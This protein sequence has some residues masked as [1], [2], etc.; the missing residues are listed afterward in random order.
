MLLLAAL[1]AGLVIE[2]VLR[3]HGEARLRR[4][5]S[6]LREAGRRD[7]EKLEVLEAELLQ[8]RREKAG[9]PT[10]TAGESRLVKGL[11]AKLRAK[12]APGAEPADLP[13]PAPPEGTAEETVSSP[14][15]SAAE[16]APAA[17]PSSPTEADETEADE[18]AMLLAVRDALSHDLVELVLQPVVSLPQRRRRFYE[19]STRIRDGEDRIILDSDYLPVAERAGLVAA[20][21]NILLFRCIQLVRLL[22]RRHD[23][24]DFFCNVSPASLRDEHFFADFVD[25]LA[26]QPEPAEHL[27][28]EFSHA[29]FEAQGPRARD[30]LERLRA[31]GCR[32]SV[33]CLEIERF[34][35]AALAARGAAFVKFDAASLLAWVERHG[36]AAAS[37]LVARTGEAGLA[38]V[39][40]NVE[41]EES[42]RELLDFGIDF[43]QGAL[44]GEP[45]P[46]RRAA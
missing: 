16:S 42:L 7:R 30:L 39:V 29:S 6:R 28:F 35:P 44:F 4:E 40:E 20:I 22:R 36:P 32:L 45:R 12:R 31:L 27:I 33:D 23:P 5:L 21:D 13:A 41:D 1:V 34:Q 24:I 26:Q 19:C 9:A 18:E 43:G 11:F 3:R 38:V 17:E 25:Y 14:A 15:P 8:I 2:M 37:D 10:S 46:A